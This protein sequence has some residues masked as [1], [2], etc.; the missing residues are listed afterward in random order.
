MAPHIMLLHFLGCCI[1]QRLAPLTLYDILLVPKITTILYTLQRP[2]R[3]SL[4]LNRETV[5]PKITTINSTL[6]S[7]HRHSLDRDCGPKASTIE[8]LLY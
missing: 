1:Q 6:Q 5:V 8:S 7:P 4:M 2:H 3:H